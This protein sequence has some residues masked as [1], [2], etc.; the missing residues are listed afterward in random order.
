MTI[1]RDGPHF[2]IE[3]GSMTI[4]ELDPPVLWDALSVL[5]PLRSGDVDL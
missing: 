5:P 4:Y 1:E 2:Y 3:N